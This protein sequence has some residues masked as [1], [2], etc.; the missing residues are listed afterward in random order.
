MSD[1]RGRNEGAVELSY[2]APVGFKKLTS[3]DD[4]SVEAGF[5]WDN[6]N[7][8]PDLDVWAIRVPAGLKAADLAGLKLKLPS[9]TSQNVT[10]KLKKDGVNYVLHT[11]GGNDTLGAGEEMQ[12]MR[13]LVPKAGEDGALYNIPRPLKHLVLTQQEPIPAPSAAP[14]APAPARRPQ[15]IDRLKHSFAPIGSLPSSPPKST[16]PKPMEVDESPKKK[17]KNQAPAEE[18]EGATPKTKSKSKTKAMD[19]E[20]ETMEVDEA[21]PVTPA[22]PKKT[23]KKSAAAAATQTQDVEASVKKEKKKRKATIED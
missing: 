3:A 9:N 10:G 7:D 22:N 19:R 6:I 20:D 17:L 13:C 18:V 5:E 2:K 4:E 15:P 14:S 16:L 1:S 21:E 11:V 23:K 12:N 8:N